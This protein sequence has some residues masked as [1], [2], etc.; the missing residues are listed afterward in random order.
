M[1]DILQRYRLFA[2]LEKWQ[3]HKN[4]VYSLGYVISAYR[5]KMQDELIEIIKNWLKSILVK[6]I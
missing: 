3:F 2:N 4:E 6:D 5:V 1:L